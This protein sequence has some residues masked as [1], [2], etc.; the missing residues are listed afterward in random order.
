MLDIS[1]K[2]EMKHMFYDR[3]NRHIQSVILWYNKLKKEFPNI[4]KVDIESH[5]KSKFKEPELTPYILLQYMIVNKLD[6]NFYPV[7][8]DKIYEATIHHITMNPHHPEFWEDCF[9][10]E[11]LNKKHRNSPPEV[12]VNATEMPKECIIEMVSDW[13]AMSEEKHSNPFRLAEKNINKRWK[14][15]EEQEY[16]IYLLLK[17]SGL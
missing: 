15:T 10:P 13:C 2:P 6:Y 1:I 12:I 5:D 3:L 9:V 14:F 11:M 16:F 4:N 7:M 17:L 8:K